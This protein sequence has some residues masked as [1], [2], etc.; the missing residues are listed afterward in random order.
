MV[1]DRREFCAAIVFLVIVGVVL[2]LRYVL[3]IREFVVESVPN[4]TSLAGVSVDRFPTR[5]IL[6]IRGIAVECSVDSMC[7]RL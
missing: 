6:C 7:L 2:D 3:S 5:S 1:W 4:N